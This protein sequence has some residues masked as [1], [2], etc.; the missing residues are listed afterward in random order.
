[1]HRPFYFGFVHSSDCLARTLC[2]LPAS[3]PSGSSAR[4][5]SPVHQKDIRKGWDDLAQTK[6]R[7]DQ[8]EK[9]L[10]IVGDLAVQTAQDVAFLRAELQLVFFASGSACAALAAELADYT[11]GKAAVAS[12]TSKT[13]QKASATLQL[14]VFASK[15]RC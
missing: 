7:V 5:R 11:A 4:G 13:L 12:G 2:V 3:M 1:M 6:D 10:G 15:G 9:G 14:N 8:M